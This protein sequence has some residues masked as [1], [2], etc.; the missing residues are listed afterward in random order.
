M[1]TLDIDFMTCLIA[2]TS[3]PI[4]E[5]FYPGLSLLEKG[6]RELMPILIYVDVNQ[7]FED[8][9][10]ALECAHIDYQSINENLQNCELKNY[11]S[12]F[13]RHCSAMGYELY[14]YDKKFSEHFLH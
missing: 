7:K 4:N 13:I 2:P 14:D 8:S 3:Y 12:T 10:D 1:E 11:F 6:K 9:D 5:Q